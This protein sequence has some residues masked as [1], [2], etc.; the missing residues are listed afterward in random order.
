MRTTEHPSAITNTFRPL[1]LLAL[2]SWRRCDAWVL[3]VMS[4]VPQLLFFYD[5]LLLWLVP[6]ERREAFFLI[7]MSVLGFAGYALSLRPNMVWVR[8]A[9]PRVIWSI[10]FPA[11]ALVLRHPNVGLVP[12]WLKRLVEHLR[13]PPIFRGRS[14]LI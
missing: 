10:Y 2:L 9:E 5:R 11:L 6:G 7:L 3:L 14:A 8:A 4:S 12:A 13:V 1:L